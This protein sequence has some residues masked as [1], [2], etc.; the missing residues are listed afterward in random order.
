MAFVKPVTRTLPDGSTG[1]VMPFHVSFEGM[2]RV[3][4]CRDDDDYDSYVKCI[5]VCARRK[6]VIVIIY[7]V[8]SNHAH[9]AILAK[10]RQDARAFALEVKRRY[11]QRF[12]GKYGECGVLRRSDVDVQLL[13]NDWYLRNALA[14]IPRN[15]FDNGA[16]DLYAYKWSGFRAMFRQNS[17]EN[18]Q[19]YPAKGYRKV[20]SLTKRE[21]EEIMHT[22]DKLCGAP[23]VLNKNGELEPSSCCDAAYL[24]KAFN[25]DQSFFFKCIGNLNTSEM[26]QKLVIS[27]R[28]MKNDVEFRKDVEDTAQK[29]FSEDIS[30]LTSAQKSRIIPYIVHTTRTTVA[31]ISRVLDLP[32]DVVAKLYPKD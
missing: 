27:P 11:A 28:I 23:W 16:Q 14:Y 1:E 15:A 22:G 7:A 3:V 13:D 5:F 19:A 10:S 21:R 25:N 20:I 2:E 31:Q 18:K 9:V 24:E 17:S 32:R 6:N 30:Q 8:V 12:Q 29:W 26:T 4:L